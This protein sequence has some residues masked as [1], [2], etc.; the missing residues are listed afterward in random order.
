MEARSDGLDRGSGFILRLPADPERS[1]RGERT[2]RP[3]TKPDSPPRRIVVVDDN[4]DAAETLADYLR[5]SQHVVAVAYDGP[6]ALDLVRPTYRARLAR[7]R[8]PRVN[9]YQV[10]AR[11]R[12]E[13]G[14]RVVLVA[15]TGYGQDEDRRK[16]KEAGFDHH[17]VKPHRV[18]AALRAAR[19]TTGRTERSGVAWRPRTRRPGKAPVGSSLSVVTVPLTIV[20]T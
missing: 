17:L 2:E 16:T 20:A 13:H 11:L 1:Q 6:T 12:A 3:A 18:P 14:T 5:L 8:L 19:W 4:V 9:G 7:H 15:L 10:A